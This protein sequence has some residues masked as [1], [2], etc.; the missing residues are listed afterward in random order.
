VLLKAPPNLDAV[1]D[2]AWKSAK[3]V[4]GFLTEAEGRFLAMVAGCAPPDGSILEIGSFKGKSTVIL[5]TV[6]KAFGLEPIAAVDPHNFNSSELQELKADA[7]DSTFQ[8]FAANLDAAGVSDYVRAQRA[9]SSDVARSWNAPLR[10]LWIDGDHSYLGAKEDFDGFIRHVVPGGIVAFHDALHAFEGPIRV[11][12]EDVLRSDRFGAAGFVGSIAWAQFR[13]ADGAQFRE[14]R[15]TVERY[16]APLIPHLQNGREPKGLR[17]LMFKLR[18]SRV[19]RAA[20]D[21]QSWLSKVN[22]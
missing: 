15:K 9:Y 10:F 14:E 5:G 16:A 6:A 12:V 17:K 2:Q 21:A 7:E 3:D 1:I 18:R 11:F 4:P 13:P 19:P 8:H 22:R 20:T